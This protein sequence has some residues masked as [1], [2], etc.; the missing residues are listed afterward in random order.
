M[1]RRWRRLPLIYKVLGGNA[2]VI[3]VGAIGGTYITQ[4][5]LEVS[6]IELALFFATMGI[7]LSLVINYL[8]LRGA[9]HPIDALQR[10]V[11][12]IDR[13][14]T[15]VRASVEEIDDPQLQRFA[16]SLN[17]ML[18]RLAAHTRMIDANR[19]QLRRLSNQ[20]LSAQ[21]DERKRLARELHDDT[22]GSL[23][24]MLLN[25]E[26]CEELVPEDGQELREK[27]RST[28]ALCEQTLDNVHKMIFDLRPTL[29]DDL[30]LAS[31]VRWY[32]KHNL[33]VA[34]IQVQL[35]I[36]DKFG[37]LPAAVE[38]ALFRIAQEAITNIIRHSN[39]RCARVQLT[40]E[41]S[42]VKLTVQDDGRGF[43]PSSIER[44]SGASPRWGLFG[45]QERV[46]VLGGK[47]TVE[48]HVGQGTMLR[49]EISLE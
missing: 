13:G 24:R 45:I 20:V 37:R 27:I 35:E 18:A 42:N 12:R 49:V 31:A 17:R 25:I 9:L 7:A 21:E 16:Q 23:A 41:N 14:D 6:G 26:M 28:R 43:D 2:V 3:I 5:L 10:M 29:L 19:A 34:G 36:N 46:A 39:A 32:A 33:E 30:G 4:R 44:A 40:R 11:E 1:F 48:S 8:I 38:N 47:F 15:D 22:S